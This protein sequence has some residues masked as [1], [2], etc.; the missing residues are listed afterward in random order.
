MDFQGGN[1]T[2]TCDMI[3]R[4]PNVLKNSTPAENGYFCSLAHRDQM[5]SLVNICGMQEK[6]TSVEQCGKYLVDLSRKND[7]RVPHAITKFPIGTWCSYKVVTKCGYPSVS[8]SIDDDTTAEDFDIAYATME[9]FNKT[10]DFD[11]D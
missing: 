8:F 9:N 10:R 2:Y 3:D 11:L 4:K 5:N 1:T 7:F 6:N